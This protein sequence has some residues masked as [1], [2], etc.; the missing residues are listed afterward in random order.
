MEKINYIIATYPGITQQRLYYDYSNAVEKQLKILQHIFKQK[1]EM[2]INSL[3]K[4]ITIMVTKCKNEHLNVENYYKFDEWKLLFDEDVKII[5]QDYIGSNNYY[6]YDQW[7]QGIIKN[8]DEYTHHIIIED[9]YCIEKSLID[10]DIQLINIY[11]NKFKDN[12]GYLASRTSSSSN[13]PYHACV[14]NGIISTDTM[15]KLIDPLA[16]FYKKYNNTVEAQ[17]V[18]SCIF[19]DENIPLENYGEYFRIPFWRSHTKTLEDLSLIPNI[20]QACFI[21]VQELN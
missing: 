9:D 17:V 20:K 8:W 14:S 13:R 15:K 3:I 1:K 2:G 12:I 21:P 10:F 11:K 6:S 18:F 7:I 16:L 19:T 4:Q 5:F